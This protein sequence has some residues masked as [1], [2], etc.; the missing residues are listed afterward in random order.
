MGGDDTSIFTYATGGIPPVVE[1]LPDG[2]FAYV[3]VVNLLT[4]DLGTIVEISTDLHSWSDSS[5]ILTPVSLENLGNN[6]ARITYQTITPPEDRKFFLRY[7]VEQLRH[8]TR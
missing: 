2:N 8:T 7:R 3:V 4:D 1:L 6:L 5:P